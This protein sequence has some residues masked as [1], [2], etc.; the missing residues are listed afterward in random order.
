MKRAKCLEKFNPLKIFAEIIKKSISKSPLMFSCE[1]EPNT[2]LGQII[3]S[4]EKKE[5]EPNRA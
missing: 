2:I 5:T 4:V 3:T 1:I